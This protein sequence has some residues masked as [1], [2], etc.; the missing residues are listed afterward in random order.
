MPRQ[1]ITPS[2]DVVLPRGASFLSSAGGRSA[3]V[4]RL[5]L[6]LRAM[7]G[8]QMILQAFL[9]HAVLLSLASPAEDMLIAVGKSRS[10]SSATYSAP[11]VG[12]PEVC[13]N[14]PGGFHSFACG[15]ALSGLPP[16]LYY[17]WFQRKNGF[18][19]VR[20]D[21]YKVD[22]VVTAWGVASLV[23]G[24]LVALPASRSTG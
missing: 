13:S 16:L 21:L 6:V 8:R 23:S 14:I 9:L 12:S 20:Y 19:I 7:R 5:G 4:Q 11:S 10:Y 18:L 24:L 22:F 15:A 17:L 3:R 1:R 2:I